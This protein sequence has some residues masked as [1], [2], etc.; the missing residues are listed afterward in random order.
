MSN[1]YDVQM[2]LVDTMSQQFGV[3]IYPINYYGPTE[4][5]DEAVFWQH[6]FQSSVESYWPLDL[7]FG[8]NAVLDNKSEWLLQSHGKPNQE[9]TS[10]LALNSGLTPSD[11]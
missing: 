4:L 3:V 9:E 8:S 10:G 1:E 5:I 11:G 7:Q 6:R 2:A